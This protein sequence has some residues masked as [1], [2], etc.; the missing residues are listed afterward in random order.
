MPKESRNNSTY[1]QCMSKAS[2]RQLYQ[3]HSQVPNTLHEELT[4]KCGLLNGPPMLY[5]K[6]KLQSMLQNSN[7]TMEGP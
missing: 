6:Y 3:C 1:S 7:Y 5:Y 4:I 2:S